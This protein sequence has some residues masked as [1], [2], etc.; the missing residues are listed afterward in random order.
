MLVSPTP[1]KQSQLIRFDFAAPAD[2]A[3]L[4]VGRVYLNNGDWKFAAVGDAVRSG[5]T[6]AV[7]AQVAT[8]A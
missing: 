6:D 3:A 4:V 8:F 2:L 7:Q 5:N 1:D